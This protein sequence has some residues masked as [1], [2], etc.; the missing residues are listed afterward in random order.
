MRLPQVLAE[1]TLW[2]ANCKVVLGN[3]AAGLAAAVILKGI[4]AIADFLDE[5]VIHAADAAIE[6]AKESKK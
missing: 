5:N 1:P 2:P 4:A 3:M 6:K